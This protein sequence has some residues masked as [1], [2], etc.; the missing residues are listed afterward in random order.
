M[1][2]W[3]WVVNFLYDNFYILT[4]FSEVVMD[5]FS[6]TFVLGDATVAVADIAFGS[7]FVVFAIHTIMKWV[8]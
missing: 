2:V 6:Y 1:P 5:V 3:E 8:V 4:S 7:L